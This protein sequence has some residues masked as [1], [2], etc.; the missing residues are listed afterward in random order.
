TEKIGLGK[1]YFHFYFFKVSI[2]IGKYFNA[3]VC[4]PSIILRSLSYYSHENFGAVYILTVLCS[5]LS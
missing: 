5:L 2:L 3:T 4:A 1:N